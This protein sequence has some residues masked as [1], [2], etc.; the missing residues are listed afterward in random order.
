MRIATQEIQYMIIMQCELDV[1]EKH[2]S[3]SII[4]CTT[5]IGLHTLLDS[6]SLDALHDAHKTVVAVVSQYVRVPEMGWGDV[7]D[8]C[9]ISKDKRG[10][11]RFRVFVKQ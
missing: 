6:K 1:K 3:V 11:Q 8:V 5:K 2:I 4:N 10:C 9:R 7:V